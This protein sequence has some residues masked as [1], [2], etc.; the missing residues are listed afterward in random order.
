MLGIATARLR[1]DLER[2]ANEDPEWADLMDS[3]V[4]R[5]TDPASAARK[6]LEAEGP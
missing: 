5:E 1:R 3:V 2:K 4:R 6:L